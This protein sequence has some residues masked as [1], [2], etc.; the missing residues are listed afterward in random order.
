MESRELYKQKYEAQIREWE[1]KVAT[2]KA[3]ADKLTAQARLDLQP[4]IEAVHTRFEAASAKLHEVTSTTEEKWEEMQRSADDAWS[5]L[6]ATAEGAYD[7]MKSHRS[8]S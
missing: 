8:G 7:A 2:I 4:H 5:E 3:Q 1:A 6:K